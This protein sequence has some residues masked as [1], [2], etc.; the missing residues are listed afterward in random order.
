MNLRPV[1]E[2]PYENPNKIEIMLYNSIYLHINGR[3]NEMSP[4][5]AEMT[6]YFRNREFNSAEMMNYMWLIFWYSRY[7]LQPQTA[8]VFYDRVSS[9]LLTDHE[10][11]S[12]RVLGYYAFGIERDVF[13]ARQYVTEGLAVVDDFSLPGEEREMERRLLL[14]LQGFIDK[15]CNVPQGT[16]L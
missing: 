11:N 9:V 6:E 13:K 4:V 12:K 3:I 16:K 5:I 8:R 15:E 2:L 10:A 7:D 1:A 14:E